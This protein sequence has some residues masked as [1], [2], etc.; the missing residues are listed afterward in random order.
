MRSLAA[1]LLLTSA[2][3]ASE[4][5][6]ELDYERILESDRVTIVQSPGGTGASAMALARR[7]VRVDGPCRSACAWSFT[8]NPQACFTERASFFFHAPVDPGTGEPMPGALSYWLS[9]APAWVQPDAHVSADQMAHLALEKK[10][11]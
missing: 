8:I 2:A 10:C 11:R 9:V 6:G 4:L 7:P 3:S 5:K 1:L